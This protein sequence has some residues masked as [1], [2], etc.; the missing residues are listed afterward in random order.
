MQYQLD[1]W[2]T[3]SAGA[4]MLSLGTLLKM[5][6]LGIEHTQR[7]VALETRVAE[8]GKQIEDSSLRIQAVEV[9]MSR[10]DANV[11]EVLRRCG[12]GGNVH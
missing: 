8:H 4:F 9:M 6:S 11:Q 1:F 2:R 7:I 10:I 12:G 3:V 5:Y